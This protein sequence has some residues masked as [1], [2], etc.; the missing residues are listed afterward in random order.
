MAKQTKKE[1]KKIFV[2]DTNV[3]IMDPAAFLHMG[4]H[5][6]VIPLVVITEIDKL[7]NKATSVSVSARQVSANLDKY[8]GPDLYKNGISLGEGKGKLSI[9]NLKELNP[10]VKKCSKKIRRIIV[11]FL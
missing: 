7:K 2:L 10:E 3:L 6:V 4:E 11:L 9:F 8:F 5:D 1:E